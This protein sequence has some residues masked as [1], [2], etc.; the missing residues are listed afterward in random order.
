MQRSLFS[1]LLLA[2]LAH[3][4]DSITDAYFY[5]QSPWVDAPVAVGTGDWT[6]AFD[7][8]RA[9]VSELT[10]EEKVNLTGGVQARNGCSGNIPA[11]ERLWFPGMC[12]TDNGQGVRVTDF[13]S[14][15]ASGIHVG[16]R[17]NKELAYQRGLAMGSGF[18]KK[19]VNVMLGPWLVP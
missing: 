17:W 18:H 9:L 15:F 14:G 8:A 2:S 13:G 5:R 1:K 4:D 3:G 6:N 7:R 16:A 12:L 19:G 10:V 11:I